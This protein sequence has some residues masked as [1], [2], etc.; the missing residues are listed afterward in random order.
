MP[1]PAAPHTVGPQAAENLVDCAL[2]RPVNPSDVAATILDI[3]SIQ[4][5]AEGTL[6]MAVKKS[7]RT[8][9][10]TT[11]QIIQIDVTVDVQYGPGQVA[12]FTGQLMAGAMSAGG[13][14]GSAVLSDDNNLVGLLFAGSDTTTIINRIQDVFS[15]LGVTL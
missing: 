8:T 3:G 6:G 15:L 9:G 14:S 11:G 10:F 7:G 13:D 1:Q 5:L 12:R 4:G 2:A